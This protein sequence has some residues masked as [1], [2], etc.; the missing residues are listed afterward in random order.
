MTGKSVF[1]IF[2]T[3]QNLGGFF[4]GCFFQDSSC[5]FGPSFFFCGD[6]WYILKNSAIRD[7]EHRRK[8]S[9]FTV[10]FRNKTTVAP[11]WNIVFTFSK[12][13]CNAEILFPWLRF[14]ERTGWQAQSWAVGSAVSVGNH[15]CLL[16][17]LIFHNCSVV[18]S[19]SF[20]FWLG[21]STKNC[22]VCVKWLKTT[23]SYRALNCISID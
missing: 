1:L 11:F 23:R 18:I 6:K 12:E 19:C 21:W 17:L 14:A 7:P 10:L 3:I 15:G 8:I 5:C 16:L 22:V 13:L 4:G 2:I 20:L 9:C